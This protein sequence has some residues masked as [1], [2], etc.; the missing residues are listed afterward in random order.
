MNTG[1]SQQGSLLLQKG[2]GIQKAH[3]RKKRPSLFIPNT[4]D[5]PVGSGQGTHSSRLANL[6]QIVPGRRGKED[7]GRRRVFQPKLEQNGVAKISF[8]RQDIMLLSTRVRRER[9]RD[10][11]SKMEVT[12]LRNLMVVLQEGRPLPG[13]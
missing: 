1:R 3:A 7:G 6:K 4:D 10:S 2:A 11:V 8:D 12:A 5:V 9:A 13:S